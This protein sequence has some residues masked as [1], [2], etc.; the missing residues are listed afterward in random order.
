LNVSRWPG[1][2]V[3]VNRSSEVI[4]LAERQAAPTRVPVQRDD[5]FVRLADEHLDKA[6]RL[7]RAI[8]RDPVEAQDA[9]HDAF[10]QAWRKWETL[11]D[12]SKFEAW[13][14]RILVNTCRNRIRTNRRANRQAATD[15]SAEVA[16]A[17]GDHAG[18]TEDRELLGAALATL[19][20]DHRI[21]V[22]LRYYRDLPVA[23]IA[24][25]LGIPVG[26]V[27]S[28]LHY[29]LQRLHEAIDGVDAE[30]SVR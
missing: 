18:P 20:P 12:R 8:L 7:A 21:V 15:I 27:Q 26:T 30:G 10:V 16:T 5:A 3:I 9:T 1:V 29:A 23:E 4:E 28:R 24:A 25:R 13:F 2:I 19:S 14:D 6:Y 11:R 22:A 17:S